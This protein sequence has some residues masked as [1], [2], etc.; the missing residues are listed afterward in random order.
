[1]VLNNGDRGRY[2]LL[3]VGF[4]GGRFRFLESRKI[5]GM[6]FDHDLR[7]FRIEFFA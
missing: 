5:I 4:F 6:I 1:M 3:E 7:V 2:R